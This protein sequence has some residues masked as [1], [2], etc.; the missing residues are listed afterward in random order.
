MPEDKAFGKKNCRKEKVSRKSIFP[1][2]AL[3]VSGSKGCVL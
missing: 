1:T 3:S 2:T